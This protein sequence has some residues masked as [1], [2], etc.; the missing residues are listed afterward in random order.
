M[1]GHFA[2]GTCR[3]VVS[4]SDLV[5]GT[6]KADLD[7]ADGCLRPAAARSDRGGGVRGAVSGA[8]RPRR[9]DEASQSTAAAGH[10]ALKRALIESHVSLAAHMLLG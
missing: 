9:P 10:V 8:A 2:Y 3:G 1:H 6:G 5:A 4:A 7:L